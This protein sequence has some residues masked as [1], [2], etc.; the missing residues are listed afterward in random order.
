ML[1]R[2]EPDFVWLPACERAERD[3]SVAFENDRVRRQA[4][5]FDHTGNRG[6][7]RCFENSSDAQPRSAAT[8]AE[9]KEVRSIGYASAPLKHPLAALVLEY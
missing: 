8:A 4:L 6:T 5:L 3:E 1:D 2:H 9:P 7:C